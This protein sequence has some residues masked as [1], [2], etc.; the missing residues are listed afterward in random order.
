MGSFGAWF[1][2]EKDKMIIEEIAKLYGVSVQDVEKHYSEM[3]A[4]IK[5]EIKE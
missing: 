4:K 3:V 1:F 2:G 5:N